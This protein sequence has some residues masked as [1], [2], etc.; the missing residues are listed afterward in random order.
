MSQSVLPVSKWNF[1][2]RVS[3][4]IR[5]RVTCQLG[6][7]IEYLWRLAFRKRATSPL[8]ENSP[9]GQRTPDWRQKTAKRLYKQYICEK[10]NHVFD[11]RT[12]GS[13]QTAN[14]ANI[15]KYRVSQGQWSR[16]AFEGSEY[17]SMVRTQY[18]KRK[19]R[20]ISAITTMS[21]LQCGQIRFRLW[22]R[23]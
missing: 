11:P 10:R 19:L 22:G 1:P 5:Y 2:Q 12:S 15:G 20:H 14:L 4:S 16:I 13:P 21:W 8:P 6:I 9:L 7:M 18:Y 17:V 23:M 3:L